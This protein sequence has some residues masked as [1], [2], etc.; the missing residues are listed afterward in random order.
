MMARGSRLSS[1]DQ[2]EVPAAWVVTWTLWSSS[3]WANCGSGRLIGKLEVNLVPLVSLPETLPSAPNA[4]EAT[5][6]AAMSLLS[7]E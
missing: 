6:P 4:T 2:I 3:S 1:T 7:W 5:C